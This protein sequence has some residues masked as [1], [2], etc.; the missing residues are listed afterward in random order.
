MLEKGAPYVPERFLHICRSICT[1]KVPAHWL[2]M[3]RKG[4]CTL[5]PYVPERFLHIGSICA[6]KVPA[7]LPERFLHICRKGSCTFA[8]LYVPE[9]FLHIF[10]SIWAGKVP[11]HWL[12]MCRKGSCTFAGKVP[13]HLPLYMCRKVPAHFPLHMGRKG[14]CTLNCCAGKIQCQKGSTSERFRPGKVNS[15]TLLCMPA[16]KVTKI[17]Y[18]NS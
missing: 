16:G 2:H 11:A 18:T 8:A 13:A 9:R 1:G 6:G 12:H 10:C 3:Y 5:A 17:K 4:S 7:H 15:C 14:S